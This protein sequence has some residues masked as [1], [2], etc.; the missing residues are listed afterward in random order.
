MFLE[1]SELGE[2]FKRR[3]RKKNR[4]CGL[5]LRWSIVAHDW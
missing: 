1:E 2:E 4:V 5:R 3:E